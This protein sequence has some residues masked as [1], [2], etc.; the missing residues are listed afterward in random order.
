MQLV[1]TDGPE[2]RES[3]MEVRGDFPKETKGC[4][5]SVKV[6]IQLLGLTPNNEVGAS[7]YDVEP[8]YPLYVSLHNLHPLLSA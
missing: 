7:I 6:E 5:C 2:L 8:L 4:P 1:S 3:R